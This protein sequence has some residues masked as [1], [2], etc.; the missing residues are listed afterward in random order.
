MSEL[1]SEKSARSAVE[2]TGVDK[3][4]GDVH[5]LSEIELT[6][7]DGEFVSLIG[8]SGCGKS[9]LLRVVADLEQ[10]TAG[11]VQVGG[12]PARQ[13]RLDQDYGI[14][15]QQSGLLE[16]RTVAENVELPAARARRRQ[17]GAAGARG[18]AAGAGRARPTSPGRGPGSSRAA[19]SSAWRSRGRWRRSRS[20]C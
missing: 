15:F 20:C 6:L 5:A 14:A 1:A 13:A 2:L 7:D 17:G 3:R 10:P 9:T 18:R 8:P 12:K 16:W 19:C 4:F 11:T